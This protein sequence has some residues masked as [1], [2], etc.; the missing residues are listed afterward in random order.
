MAYQSKVHCANNPVVGDRLSSISS[1]QPPDLVSPSANFA[2]SNTFTSSSAQLITELRQQLFTLTS[3][4]EKERRVNTSAT[5]R[6]TELEHEVAQVRFGA[7]DVRAPLIRPQAVKAGFKPILPSQAFS[8]FQRDEEVAA[9]PPIWAKPG[10]WNGIYDGSDATADNGEGGDESYGSGV[11]AIST[12][13][14]ANPEPYA[15]GPEP[16]PAIG[17]ARPDMVRMKS[18]GFPTAA[19]SKTSPPASVKATKRESFFALP[20]VLRQTPEA[21]G[22]G[23][24]L[25]CFVM[26]DQG[27]AQSS[28]IKQSWYGLSGLSTTHDSPVR[29]SQSS[30][31]PPDTRFDQEF[32]PESHQSQDL[33]RTDSS[34]SAES[35]P[36]AKSAN[37]NSTSTSGSAS[38]S[39]TDSAVS[40]LSYLS[41]W[42]S[43]SNHS[44]STAQEDMDE[45]NEQRENRLNSSVS[46]ATSTSTST[47]GSGSAPESACRS[48]NSTSG[49]QGQAGE[50]SNDGDQ[51]PR[52][53]FGFSRLTT[54]SGL[55]AGHNSRHNEQGENGMTGKGMT[56]TAGRA[57]DFRVG[58]RCC[59]GEVIEL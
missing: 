24:D 5:G 48:G 46:S 53:V 43:R 4:L 55:A 2:T 10:G 47:S 57:M 16:A 56:P 15:P 52:A 22:H 50:Y 32:A 37:S 54:L 42:M 23:V 49:E 12:L 59:I 36:S 51:T 45:R 7:A 58:C 30:S 29:L 28:A 21:E 11:P 33:V 31:S 20:E 18:W 35:A 40:A 19:N 9:P 17:N 34:Q 8:T 6:I 1:S 38:G 13:P 39:I 41:S 44:S 27:S 14:S 25:P 3:S 26:P